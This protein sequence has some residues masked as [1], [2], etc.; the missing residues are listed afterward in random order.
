MSTHWQRI[1]T[2]HPTN[3]VTIDV[4]ALP[5]EPQAS[6]NRSIHLQQTDTFI[7]RTLSLYGWIFVAYFQKTN[8]YIMMTKI[9]S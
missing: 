4:S 3:L 5:T 8:Y 1:S 7:F 6:A 2:S 9:S